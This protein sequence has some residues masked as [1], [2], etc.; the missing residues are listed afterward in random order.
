MNG[1]PTF[2]YRT[3]VASVVSHPEVFL[4]YGD[5]S[6]VKLLVGIVVGFKYITHLPAQCSS[7]LASGVNSTGLVNRPEFYRYTSL[8]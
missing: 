2:H 6:T 8:R 7:F 1:P 4:W 3:S 5:T